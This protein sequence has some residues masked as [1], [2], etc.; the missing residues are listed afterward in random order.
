MKT[1][2]EK[3]DSVLKALDYVTDAVKRAE[4]MGDSYIGEHS[5]ISEVAETKGLD[6]AVLEREQK[7][8][9]WRKVDITIRYKVKTEADTKEPDP[10]TNELIEGLISQ[11]KEL[12]KA[13]RLNRSLL[14]A[15][16]EAENGRGDHPTYPPTE[17]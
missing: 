15:L 1:T 16:Y 12:Q 3:K 9:G 5:E 17:K 14:R 8:T 13:T 10:V 7:P 6:G 11:V 2:T 4:E